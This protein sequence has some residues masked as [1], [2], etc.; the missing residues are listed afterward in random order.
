MVVVQAGTRALA[1]ALGTAVCLVAGALPAAALRAPDTAPSP[2][3]RAA[4]PVLPPVGAAA[5]YQLGGA[6]P[7]PAGVRIV[8][9]DR[10]DR[11]APGAY[12]LCYVNAFQT[13]PGARRWWLTRHPGLVLRTSAG[14]PVVDPGWPDEMLLDTRTAARRA[15]IAAIVSRWIAGCAAAGYQAVE[16]DNLDTWTRSGARLRRAHNAALAAALVRAAHARGLAVAQKNDVGMLP[17]RRSIGFDFAVVEECQAYGECARFTAAYGRQVIE[18]EYVENGGW[19]GFRRAC[20]A[21]GASITV[22]LRDRDLVP[23]GR[24]GYRYA[25]C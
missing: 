17:L 2:A 22:V 14:R 25:T 6:Y 4:A 9:R 21:R 16:L 12:S 19:T 18:I 1:A 24:P 23:R 8:A 3:A 11:P 13:Q 20:A 7:L 5:D 15:A 10:A